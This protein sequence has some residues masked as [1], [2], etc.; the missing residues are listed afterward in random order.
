M[1]NRRNKGK[2]LSGLKVMVRGDDLNGALRVL[3][4]RMQ[5]EGVFNETKRRNLLEVEVKRRDFNDSL[6]EE[7]G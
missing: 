7:D 4:K 5:T 3:K 2:T 1:Q 6:V